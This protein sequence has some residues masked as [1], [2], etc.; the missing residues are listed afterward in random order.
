MKTVLAL[1]I[2]LVSLTWLWHALVI[3]GRRPLWILRQQGLCLSRLLSIALM[4]LAMLL[5]TRPAWLEVP[6]GGMDRVY[7]GR[8]WAGILACAFAALDWRQLHLSLSSASRIRRR[9]LSAQS[10]AVLN[11]PWIGRKCGSVAGV[12]CSGS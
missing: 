2:A 7:R 11:G 12:F 10:G 4:S 6:L 3:G 9:I 1:M 5:A 8:K